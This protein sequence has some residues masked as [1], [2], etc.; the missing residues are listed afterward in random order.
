MEKF[1]AGL[2]LELGRNLNFNEMVVAAYGYELSWRR[3][4]VVCIVGHCYRGDEF[5]VDGLRC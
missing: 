3:H 1:L 2:S 4:T 5:M